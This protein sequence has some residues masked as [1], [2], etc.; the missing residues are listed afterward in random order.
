MT[1][2]QGAQAGAQAG[3]DASIRRVLKEE[4]DAIENRWMIKTVSVVLAF[5]GAGIGVWSRPELVKLLQEHGGLIAI[6]VIALAV[7]GF[8]LVK[9]RSKT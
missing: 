3:Q 2:L 8:F 9:S 6:F 7:A 4:S 5:V 1:A